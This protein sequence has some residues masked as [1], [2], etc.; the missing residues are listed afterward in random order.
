MK[1]AAIGL[2]VFGL[3]NAA[4]AT[5]LRLLPKGSE[6]GVS[7]L[8]GKIPGSVSLPDG[9]REGVATKYLSM[10]RQQRAAVEVVSCLLILNA[11]LCG[12]G[13]LLFSPPSWSTGLRKKRIPAQATPERQGQGPAADGCEGGEGREE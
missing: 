9:V 7:V 13:M 12:Y 3:M 10:F 8:M 2:L 11:I 1:G 6:I 5:W 4:A